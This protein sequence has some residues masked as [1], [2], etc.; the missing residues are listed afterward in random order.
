MPT[1]TGQ[2]AQFRDLAWAAFE[3]RMA[4][5]P[6]CILRTPNQSHLILVIYLLTE[7]NGF[8][9]NF[10]EDKFTGDEEVEKGEVRVLKGSNMW[11]SNNLGL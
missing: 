10:Y 5:S 8:F 2:V 3:F 4:V 6:A 1:C 11:C 9:N 7:Y